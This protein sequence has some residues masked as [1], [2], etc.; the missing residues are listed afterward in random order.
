[1]EKGNHVSVFV[2]RD[3]VKHEAG[4]SILLFVTACDVLGY[5]VT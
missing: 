2:K 4:D 1:M 5:M 3:M